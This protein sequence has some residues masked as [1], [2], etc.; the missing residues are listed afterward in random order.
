M[1][2][3]MFVASSSTVLAGLFGMNWRESPGLP[4]N[5]LKDQIT[6]TER[7]GRCLCGAISFTLSAE[8]LVTR[9]CWCRDCQHLAANGTVNLMVPAQALSISGTLAE[10]TK[11]AASG[12][13][14]TRMFC[15]SCGTHLFARS[16]ARPEFRVVRVGN[17]D[18]TSS[19][20]PSLNIWASS[21]PRWV[22][23]D[24]TL[25]RVA[26]QPVPPPAKPTDTAA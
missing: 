12:N 20:Q 23:M 13:A 5:L 17:L 21:A 18:D 6:M 10:H 22:C 11:L 15:P 14:V 3:A 26:G 9:V 4:T 24:P 19:V 16:N 7:T 1:F 8:P 2:V 25:E